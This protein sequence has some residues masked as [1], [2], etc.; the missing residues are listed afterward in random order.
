MFR[1]I[2]SRIRK[3]GPAGLTLVLALAMIGQF[4]CNPP[5]TPAPAATSGPMTAADQAP[6]K[7]AA[8]V[9]SDANKPAVPK[10]AVIGDRESN[11]GP[12]AAKY[13]PVTQPQEPSPFRFVDIL[14]GS[15]VDFKHIS[16]M[17]D[18]KHFPTA[19]GSGLALFDYDGDGKLDLYFC[20]ATFLPLGTART[21][22]SKLYRNLGNGKYQDVTS[23]AGVGYEGFCHGAVVGDIDNDGDQ[24]LFLCNYGS[25][26]LY[27]NNGNGTFTDISKTAGVGRAG[28]SS[29]G[30]FLDYDNDGDLDLYVANY[31]IWNYPEDDLYCGNVDHT[32]RF[33]C[34]PKSI[35]TTKHFFYRNNGDGTFTDVYDEFLRSA[36]GKK[37]PGRSDGHG[38][39]VVAADLNGD[40]KVDLYVANDMNP[41]F[42]FFNNGDGTFEDATE[43]SGA[44]YDENG[45]SQS[46]MGADAEDVDGDGDL[47]LIASNFTNEYNTLHL[48]LGHGS[49]RDMTAFWGMA[50]DTFPYVGWG[51]GLRDFDNDGW[52]DCFVANGHVDDN[53]KLIGQ[54]IEH[55]DRVNRRFKLSTRDVGPY[56][57]TNHVAR[58]A[59]FGDIDDDGDV[60]IVVSH[61]D[62]VPAI[63]RN[64]TPTNNHWLR[65]TLVGTKSNRDAVGARVVF[66]LEKRTI[67]QYRKGGCSVF[68]ANDPRI[69]VG[70]GDAAAVKTLTIHWPSGAKTTRTNVPTNQALRIVEGE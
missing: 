27:R 41:A 59:A 56:F 63:L 29:G 69:V 65:L 67:T 47:D 2:R 48:N 70:L 6:P 11:S 38:F 1:L 40:D 8:G 60:D 4:G 39:G 9:K 54:D 13:K 10:V 25:N 31:G 12:T 57:A 51:I 62:G 15:G 7:P 16:G 36:E 49:F 18:A 33:Y 42:L 45:Q 52:P 58:G 68:V 37:I 22:P 43:S 66:E 50:A 21:G 23:A 19:N 28:W 5:A 34:N 35:K 61:K 55:K 24:D 20:N 14:E 30:A 46:G 3:R 64:D 32:V 26:A 17:N 53:R 44:A